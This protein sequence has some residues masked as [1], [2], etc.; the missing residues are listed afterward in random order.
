MSDRAEMKE[1]IE[2][3]VSKR[4]RIG[5]RRLSIEQRLKILNQIYDAALYWMQAAVTAGQSKGTGSAAI[6]LKSTREEIVA[7]EHQGVSQMDHNISFELPGLDFS[8]YEAEQKK[9]EQEANA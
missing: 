3:L 7:W 4:D 5:K 9:K 8:A 6:L 2:A 1:K